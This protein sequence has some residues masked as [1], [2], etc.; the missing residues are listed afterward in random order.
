VRE[1]TTR[2]GILA[3]ALALAGGG[4]AIGA[5][6]V[7]GGDDAKPTGRAFTL[8]TPRLLLGDPAA[9]PGM[10][11]AASRLEGWAD[12]LDERGARAGAFTSVVFP[13]G[14]QL[15]LHTFALGAGTLLGMGSPGAAG[16]AVVGGTGDY[17]GASGAYVLDQRRDGSADFTFD[18]SA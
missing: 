14:S 10:P 15:E 5:A 18:L 1:R 8:T 16:F 17:A 9:R 3:G 4:A 13:G 2:R 6:K 11:S 12:L 7:A